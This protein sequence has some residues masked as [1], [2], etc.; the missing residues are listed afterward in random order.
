VDSGGNAYVGGGSYSADFPT[1]N[2]LQATLYNYICPVYTVSGTSPYAKAY[3]AS[4]GFL[5]ALNPSGSGLLWS[6]Y[7]GS[8]AV[9][10][11]TLDASGNVYT[12]G[13][14]L[15]ITT[16]AIAPSKTASVGVLKI[17]PQGAG[18]QFGAN[19]IVNAA[20]FHPGL[21]SPGGLA[22]LFVTGLNVTGVQTASG[23][24]LPIELAGVTILVQ[25]VPAPILAVAGA[26]DGSYQQIN[27]QVPFDD[28]QD[29]H[30]RGALPG[31]LDILHPATGRARNLRAER[32]H[33]GHPARG[34]LQPG[35][36]FQSGK[37]GR[38]DRRL[39]DRARSGER[40]SHRR[41]SSYR[42]GRRLG[43]DLLG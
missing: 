43:F 20:S 5:S 40:G 22:S 27:F 25:G 33:A 1:V 9:W 23:Y 28:Q 21:P 38:D 10:A 30:R 29:E 34:R 39:R 41:R 15:D 14:N 17:A 36:P 7:L 3:C 37:T 35:Y 6:T 2:P 32:R 42:T 19:S 13:V 24:P 16:P 31:I 18:L 26:P 4:A 12:T 8:G 11:I